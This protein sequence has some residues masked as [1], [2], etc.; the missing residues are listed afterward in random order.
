MKEKSTGSFIRQGKFFDPIF[1]F[2]YVLTG[3]RIILGNGF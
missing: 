1:R 2:L 3:R